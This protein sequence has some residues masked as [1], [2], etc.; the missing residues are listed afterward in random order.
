MTI[1]KQI[2]ITIILIAVAIIFFGISNIDYIVQDNFYNFTT[3]SWILDRDAEPYKFIF[4]DGIKNLLTIFTL[5]LIISLIFFKKNNTVKSYRK[6]I[7]IV[8]LSMI[9]I[10][11][12]INGIKK[13]TN[14]PCPKNE[15][16]YG[17]KMIKTAVWQRYAK[18]YE[19]MNHIACWPAG[20]AS[21]GFALMSLF[22]LFKT[23]KNKYI[24]LSVA[25]TVGWSMGI[26]KMLIGDHFLSH[27]IL[28]MIIAWLIILIIKKSI[29]KESYK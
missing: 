7:I 28:T 18:P 27:T 6:E 3:H 13:F 20:H 17:G 1:N 4:Y 25:L 9:L 26:Y 29:F 14:M 23:K 2:F 11:I 5:C 15:I 10:P 22:F 8:V 21:G 16:Y 24:A 19:D 12:T